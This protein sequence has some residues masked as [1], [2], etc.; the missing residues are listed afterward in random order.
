MRELLG[1]VGLATV[2]HGIAALLLVSNLS[3]ALQAVSAEGLFLAPGALAVGGAVAALLAQLGRKRSQ[4]TWAGRPTGC[5]YVLAMSVA[6]LMAFAVVCS[7][8]EAATA[9]DRVPSRPQRVSGRRGAMSRET[10]GEM[11]V[12]APLRR[13][14]RANRP[15]ESANG[16][17]P[18]E[19]PP[20]TSA[21]AEPQPPETGQQ[22][23]AANSRSSRRLEQLEAWLARIRAAV[24]AY[25]TTRAGEQVDGGEPYSH[26]DSDTDEPLANAPP[27][28]GY[29]RRLPNQTRRDPAGANRP[30]RHPAPPRWRDPVDAN[31]PVGRT[32]APVGRRPVA[33][34][35]T[36]CS[37]EG[38]VAE[39]RCTGRV[40]RPR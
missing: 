19:V 2:L 34:D 15:D 12:A 36:R 29:E 1:Q 35:T 32:P 4:A 17:D 7:E 37:A 24:E 14:T 16:A 30:W 31:T 28:N 11:E 23:I 3:P 5:S 9:Q 33:P 21:D 22:P 38:A 27:P 25:R 26:A 40:P 18:R 8:A 6:G 10:G 20:P 39:R 13:P